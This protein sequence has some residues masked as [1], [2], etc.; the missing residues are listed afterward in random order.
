MPVYALHWMFVLRLPSSQSFAAAW[1]HLDSLSC[2][3]EA[4]MQAAMGNAEPLAVT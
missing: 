1:Q 3:P 4:V 2:L